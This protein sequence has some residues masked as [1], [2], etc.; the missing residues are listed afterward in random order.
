[1]KYKGWEILPEYHTGADFTINNDGRTRYRKPTTRDINY[2]VI[3]DDDGKRW[4]AENTI[5]ECKKT[6]DDFHQKL[7]DHG[8]L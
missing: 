5:G 8:L 1:M 3:Y 7:K 4:I 6:I 2:Y